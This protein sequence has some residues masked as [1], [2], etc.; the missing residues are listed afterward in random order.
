MLK[1]ITPQE[2]HAMLDDN[3]VL[4]D[5]REPHEQAAERIPGSIDMPLS[6]LARGDTNG[7]PTD[8]KVIFLCASG[9]RTKVNSAALNHLAGGDAYC[10][11]GGI[12]GWKR[13][14]FGTDRG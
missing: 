3:A 7:L 6:K 5:V 11:T 13:A 10:M 14:G 12:I 2:A 1:D 8:R 9:G 4:V